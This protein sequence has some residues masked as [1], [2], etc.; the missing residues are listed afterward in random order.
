[1]VR[2]FATPTTIEPLSLATFIYCNHH[3]NDTFADTLADT[4]AMTKQPSATGATPSRT[5][6]RNNYAMPHTPIA[7]AKRPRSS[8]DK[9]AG[10]KNHPGA[11]GTV[12]ATPLGKGCDEGAAPQTPLPTTPVG[13]FATPV[14]ATTIAIDRAQLSPMHPARPTARPEQEATEVA[15]GAENEEG[16]SKLVDVIFSPMLKFLGGAEGE[17]VEEEIGRSELEVLA[18]NDSGNDCGNDGD[19]T[20]V[21]HSPGSNA[22]ETSHKTVSH[23]EEMEEPPRNED[24]EAD[25]ASSQGSDID[26]EEFNPYAFIKSLPDYEEVKSF[27]PTDRL[28][29]K[30]EDAPPIS[31]VLDL[32]ETL[33]HCTVEAVDDADLTFPVEFHG[34]TYQVYV[35]LRPH[36]NTFLEAIADKFEVIV[37]T[38]SQQVYADAL[39]NL[40]DPEKKYIKHRMFRESCLSVEGNFLKDLNVLGRDL[41]KSVLVDN[42]PHAF[43]YQVDNGIPIESWFDDQNDTELLKLERFLRTLHGVKDV[44]TVVRR[45]FQTYRLIANAP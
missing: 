39:L 23:E 45:S 27:C 35:R 2:C 43:G 31:L 1:L 37:F 12:P 4:F 15:D 32:D 25:D 29:A 11:P 14:V 38:A 34:M 6:A 20:G 40:I 21:S 41:K 7:S 42:S 3:E 5:T 10:A 36:L 18:E 44:R 17:E 28:P 8:M 26:E 19:N 22:M 24:V 30:D 16:A 33:V 9:A 13:G